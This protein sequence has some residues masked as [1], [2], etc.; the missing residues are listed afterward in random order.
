MINDYEYPTKL[1]YIFV[2]DVDTLRVCVLNE[3]DKLLCRG[4]DSRVHL[5][6]EIV[7]HKVRLVSLTKLPEDLISLHR[8]F[9]RFDPVLVFVK[10]QLTLDGK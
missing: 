1:S 6:L 10:N 3:A 8:K 5:I 9:F 4:F 7:P 2:A